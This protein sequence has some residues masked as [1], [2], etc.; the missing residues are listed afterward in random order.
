MSKEATETKFDDV[1]VF[2]KEA[3]VLNSPATVEPVS[4]YSKLLHVQAKLKAP[5]SNF[6]KFGNYNFRNCEDILESVKP[7]L[8]EVGATLTIDDSIQF[9][10][11]RY[12]VKAIA[13]FTDVVTSEKITVSAFAREEEDKKGFDAA[14][15]SGSTSSY[16][17]KYAL[18]GL[19]CIDDTKDADTT[20]T[21]GKEETNETPKSTTPPKTYSK[22][23]ASNKPSTSASTTTKATPSAPVTAPPK[24][25]VK[26]I[27]DPQKNA[28]N[29]TVGHIVDKG[30]EVSLDALITE[31]FKKDSL[32]K[33]TNQDARVLIPKLN[34]ILR[35]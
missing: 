4:V 32:D 5:K 8:A 17:R 30:I 27:S 2:N 19:F 24:A 11:E 28:I 15:L 12:Y 1:P 6:N 26:M 14:Q 21:H 35:G 34:Q 13:T 25:D 29:V 33:L 23:N 31:L 22:S 7:L 3:G 20:N 9:I 10:G 16:A 18:N